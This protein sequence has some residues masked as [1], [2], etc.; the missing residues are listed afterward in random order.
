MDCEYK[1]KTK[2]VKL[3]EN[4]EKA[5]NCTVLKRSTSWFRVNGEST[6]HPGSPTECTY[7]SGQ[8]TYS[9]SMKTP[10][11]REEQQNLKYPLTNGE[12]TIFSSSDILQ[13]GLKKPQTQKRA[14]VQTEL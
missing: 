2:T 6:L 11:I 9:S 8:N 13:P 3:L 1:L 7:K 14:L 4:K 12:F 5:L 10:Q